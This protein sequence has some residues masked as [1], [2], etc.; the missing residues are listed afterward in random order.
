MPLKTVLTVC[1]A[2]AVVLVASAGAQDTRE[3]DVLSALLT[4]VRGL[5]A[6]LEQ[7]AVVGPRVQL[8]LGR[9]QLQEQRITMIRRVESLRDAR[10]TAET[11]HARAQTEL[12]GLERMVKQQLRD[13]PP[14]STE[15]D[16]PMSAAVRRQRQ[17]VSAGA[18]D[19]QQLRA[20]EQQL[21]QQIA[22]EQGR[23]AEINRALE[24]LER[25]LGRR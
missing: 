13:M 15:A 10:R 9:L 22:A 7:S 11:G 8:A 3:P 14:G 23:W 5:R 18:A 20:E 16:H 6:A 12:E 4:E 19:L 1:C 21:E 25:S 24:E 2:I 17:G